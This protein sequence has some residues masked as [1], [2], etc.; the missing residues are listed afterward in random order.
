MNMKIIHIIFDYYNF[1]IREVF[2]GVLGYQSRDGKE[3]KLE[4]V[5]AG[6]MI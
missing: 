3:I 2:K 5:N 6:L 1:K 4:K